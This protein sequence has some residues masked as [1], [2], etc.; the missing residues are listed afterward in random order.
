M[1]SIR[2]N[3]LHNFFSYRYF[4][5]AFCISLYAT[6][7]WAE[8]AG[9]VT[10]LE[11]TATLSDGTALSKDRTIASND[12]IT[13]G[14][15]SKLTL[16]MIDDATIILG[17]NTELKL[18]EYRFQKKDTHNSVLMDITRGFFRTISGKIGNN[19]TDS[20]Q[21][22]GRLII[23]GIQG[24]EYEMLVNE[25]EE[26]IQAKHGIII[27]NERC[28]THPS[29]NPPLDNKL[30]L[31]FKDKCMM[32]TAQSNL[33]GDE[34]DYRFAHL[35]LTTTRTRGGNEAKHLKWDKSKIKPKDFPAEFQQ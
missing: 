4:F 26:F 35:T 29:Q 20:Y 32:N 31:L 18:K 7:A 19:K 12:T 11:G 27:A 21:L 8:N 5:L 28:D 25:T 10:A 13:T 23:I 16:A 34:Q 24:T 9:V 15:D 2:H 30:K 33:F 14:K 17:A 22:R 1:R 6:P 3:S